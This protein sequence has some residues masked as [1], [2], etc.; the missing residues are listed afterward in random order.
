MS[1]KD[2]FERGFI[3]GLEKGKLIGSI[4][5]MQRSFQKVSYSEKDLDAMNAHELDRLFEQMQSNQDE[6]VSGS[7]EEIQKCQTCGLRNMAKIWVKCSDRFNF[8]SPLTG[9]YEGYVPQGIGIDMEDGAGDYIGFTYCLDCG[10]IQGKFP[11]LLS[12]FFPSITNCELEYLK[13]METKNGNQ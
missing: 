13:N 6:K 3:Q 7:T 9:E 12:G 4:L 10:Q 11:L 2:E 1:F 5:S 8:K